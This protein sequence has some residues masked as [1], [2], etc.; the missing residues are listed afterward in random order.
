MVAI[1]TELQGESLREMN[2]T[3][4]RR[5]GQLIQRVGNLKTAHT[6]T[7]RA[8]IKEPSGFCVRVARSAALDPLLPVEPSLL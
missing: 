8:T 1:D 6:R 5:C 4:M 2:F 3:A 7:L